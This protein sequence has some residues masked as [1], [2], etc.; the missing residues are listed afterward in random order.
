MEER[1]RRAQYF[2]DSL[3]EDQFRFLVGMTMSERDRAMREA[4]AKRYREGSNND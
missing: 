4:F 1:N 2:I 3:S